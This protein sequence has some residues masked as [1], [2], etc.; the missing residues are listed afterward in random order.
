M[1]K[2]D[3]PDM[4]VPLDCAFG[5]SVFF[6]REA[7]IADEGKEPLVVFPCARFPAEPLS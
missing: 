4:V 5:G 7:R 3:D 6:T 1:S 2:A